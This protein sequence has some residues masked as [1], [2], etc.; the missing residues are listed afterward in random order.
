V[1]QTPGPGG[2]ERLRVHSKVWVERGGTVVISEY[3]ARLLE[4][5]RATGSVAAAAESLG[6][7]YRTAWKKL[8]EMEA[9]SGAALVESG[10]GGA[11]G[12]ESHLTSDAEELLAAFQRISGPVADDVGA[13]FR[14]E[15]EHFGR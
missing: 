6:L 8:R 10:S 1:S 12:G 7:P 9:A 4:A 14:R 13:R 11:A 15:S 5:I 2:G 3:R